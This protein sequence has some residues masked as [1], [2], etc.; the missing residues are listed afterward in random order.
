MLGKAPRGVPRSI[1]V[2]QA[3]F[4][5]GQ[6]G[7]DSFG[8]GPC[9]P[10]RRRFGSPAGWP[11][12]P[13]LRE[14]WGN[15][16]RMF[17]KT[18]D[19]LRN[20]PPLAHPYPR[21][22]IAV[23]PPHP[24]KGIRN[25]PPRMRRGWGW[26]HFA[27]F[28]SF[29]AWRET[30][31]LMPKTGEQSQNVYE[32]KGPAEKSTTPGP[33]LSKEGNHD[34]RAPLLIQGGKS[35]CLGFPPQPGRG[36][37][38]SPPQMRRG[39]GWWDFAAFAAWR[40]TGFSMPKTEEQSQNVYENKGPALD[41]GAG[42]PNVHPLSRPSDPATLLGRMAHFP[43]MAV[44]QMP[45]CRERA[46]GMR[47]SRIRDYEISSARGGEMSDTRVVRFNGRG[48]GRFPNVETS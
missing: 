13:L 24:M 20:Q 23:L 26:W 34:D 43:G 30:G 33:S 19:R 48:A 32:N 4:P 12:G 21:R 10:P 1:S 31:F 39:W 15:K 41:R 35:K 7:T 11:R 29:A 17:M 14:I 47:L 27:S 25:S 6:I 22:G 45:H 3:E 36:I 46:S 40:E 9:A 28:A 8:G 37:R 42:R 38:N 44:L 16:V 5:N 2:P 18:K